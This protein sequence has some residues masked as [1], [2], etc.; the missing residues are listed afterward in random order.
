MMLELFVYLFVCL[1]VFK[2]LGPFGFAGRGRDVGA[3]LLKRCW[4]PT[5]HAST[6]LAQTTEYGPRTPG[7]A[8]GL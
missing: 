4:T 6:L 2:A 1:F 8:H 7:D 5:Y 3:I